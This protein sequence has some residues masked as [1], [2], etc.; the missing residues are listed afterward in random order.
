MWFWNKVFK[1]ILFIIEWIHES[2]HQRTERPLNYNNYDSIR[3][4]EGLN[5]RDDRKIVY[6]VTVNNYYF[7]SNNTYKKVTKENSS[8]IEY[9]E[10]SYKK[11]SNRKCRPTLL[12]YVDQ[13]LLS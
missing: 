5:N 7:N 12:E 8:N 1:C 13:P 3:N 6:N 9:I 10:D 2:I 11:T 4:E